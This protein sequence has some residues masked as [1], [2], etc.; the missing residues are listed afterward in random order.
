MCWQSNA[1][2]LNH[3]ECEEGVEFMTQTGTFKMYN[4]ENKFKVV[5]IPMKEHKEAGLHNKF[6][7][8]IWVPDE[9]ITEK[10]NDE[11]VNIRIL[12]QKLDLGAYFLPQIF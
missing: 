7:M 1:E 9:M 6:T 10:E 5:E 11:E 3:G 4:A 12:G 8:L 2:R